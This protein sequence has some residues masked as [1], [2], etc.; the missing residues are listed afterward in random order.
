MTN[1][2]LTTIVGCSFAGFLLTIMPAEASNPV[3][4]KILEAHP[5]ADADGDG[6]LSAAE[7]T[8]LIRK[9]LQK[10]PK[11]DTD[12][13]GLLSNDERQALLQ[14]AMARKK[15]QK[16]PPTS[17]AADDTG[18]RK[19][20]DLADV[21][22]GEHERQIF[23]IWFADQTRPA[24]LAI[25]IHGGGF[26]A[27]SKENL[28]PAE[29]SGLLE[30]GISV[31]AINYRLIDTAPLPTPHNDAKRALQFIRSKA[32]EWKIDKDRVGV[33]GGSAG[34]QISMWLAFSDDM[35]KPENENLLERESTR[36][37]CVA[38]TGGQTSM[39]PE[40]WLKHM[41]TILG[42]KYD[43]KDIV[44]RGQSRK[45]QEKSRLDLWGAQTAEEADAKTK[46][47]SALSLISADDPPIFM[48]YSMP[49]NGKVPDNRMKVRGWLIHHSFFG[50]ALKE[51]ADDLKMEAHLNHP[52][53][54]CEY[55]S[56]VEFF[57]DK[58]AEQ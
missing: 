32:E 43:V 11:A 52:K 26:R 10:H 44:G 29:L 18:N 19:L 50:V 14:R 36:L 34:A 39:D 20:P 6:E 21:K 27:G 57:A 24:P 25:Y 28:R 45:E 56:V 58:L 1:K 51:K 46:S 40:F 41:T 42:E 54:D 37:T 8:A 9:I 48:K 7:E 17:P 5:Q 2:N 15:K 12:G 55:E 23:D 38:T 4:T 22:Y 31:A 49:P 30:A 47:C 53:V 13:D 3:A 35:A 16:L 33:F